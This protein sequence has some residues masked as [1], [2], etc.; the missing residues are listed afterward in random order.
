MM[1]VISQLEDGRFF[2]EDLTASIP[3][4]L[5][6]AISLNKW[7]LCLQVHYDIKCFKVLCKFLNLSLHKITTGLFVENTIIVAEGEL[8]TNGTFQVSSTKLKSLHLVRSVW[9]MFQI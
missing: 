6:Q 9:I 1:G 4:D 2:L 5:S 7:C 3:I 8:Q